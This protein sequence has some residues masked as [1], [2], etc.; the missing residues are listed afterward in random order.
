L[1]GRIDLLIRRFIEGSTKVAD[2]L[3]REVLYHVARAMPGGE[4]ISAVQQLYE[5]KRLLPLATKGPDIDFIAIQPVLAKARE[6]LA[7]IR[8]LWQRLAGSE[9]VAL[10]AS[11][12]KMVDTVQ[13]L[14]R[15]AISDLLIA[16]EAS[17]R[18]AAKSPNQAILK[19]DAFGLEFSTALL[20]LENALEG[21]AALPENHDDQALILAE[22]LQ[23]V[24]VG[25]R[26]PAHLM[27]ETGIS[28]MAQKAENKQLFKVLAREIRENL[29]EIESTLDAMV[30]NP[31]Q[32]FETGS[33]NTKFAEIIGALTLANKTEAKDLFQAIKAKV[34]AVAGAGTIS[35]M[36]EI[37]NIADALSGFGFYLTA[38]E[39]QLD[40]D[41]SSLLIGLNHVLLGI[42]QH[43]EQAL[44]ER[45]LEDDYSEVR[46]ALHRQLSVQGAATAEQETDWSEQLQEMLNLAKLVG[47]AS[48]IEAIKTWREQTQGQ[49]WTPQ[50]RASLLPLLSDQGPALPQVSAET[51]KVLTQSTAE[52]D[53]FLLEVF[54]EESQEVLANIRAAYENMALK[55]TKTFDQ[56]ADDLVIIRRGYHTLKGSGRMVGLSQLSER[57]WR[58]E[59]MLNTHL[60][61]LAPLG[62][63]TNQM[64]RT[65]TLEFEL[66]VNALKQNSK[67]QLSYETLEPALVIAEEEHSRL[68]GDAVPHTAATPSNSLPQDALVN[69]QGA[70]NI[71]SEGLTAPAPLDVLANWSLVDVP[72][73][74]ATV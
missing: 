44:P 12:L 72:E 69:T 9:T 45:S 3:R 54:L 47:A 60:E 15:R 20:F 58:V 5:L 52:Q 66:W 38:Q 36:G 50:S 61:K 13:P 33:L 42:D 34:D 62:V 32:K 37:S 29:S 48:D 59:R 1:S 24:A 40:R 73:L 43:T 18:Q 46:A 39:N 14:S 70:G 22:R 28:E 30:R 8:I 16:M 53:D 31:E 25:E 7:D 68:L 11:L 51:T 63:A 26:M 64:L 56:T 41:F 19:N 55:N 49:L 67:A 2:R 27:Y 17:I 74:N 71:S 35:N 10:Q 23:I 21:I 4:Q 6:A 65:A 57:A